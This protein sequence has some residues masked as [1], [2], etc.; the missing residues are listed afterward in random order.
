MSADRQAA[1]V[2]GKNIVI[3]LGNSLAGDEGIG[4]AV[5][6][7]LPEL[8]DCRDVECVDLGTA[9]FSLIHLLAGRRTAV[10][11]DCAFMNTTP[12]S[13]RCFSPESAR[14]VKEFSHFSLHEGDVFDVLKIAQEHAETPLPHIV[15]IGVQPAALGWGLPLS[16][17]ITEELPDICAAVAEVIGL[18]RRIS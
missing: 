7:R 13:I 10:I 1:P 17:V 16:A 3:G 8:Y 11:I 15:L 14:C 6:E 12:G 18:S 2:P 9:G 5:V 4:P